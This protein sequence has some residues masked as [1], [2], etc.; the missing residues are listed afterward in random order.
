MNDAI[1]PV[2]LF[3]VPPDDG[4]WLPVSMETESQSRIRPDEATIG[5]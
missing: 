5:E 1:I 2:V 3:V 4:Y